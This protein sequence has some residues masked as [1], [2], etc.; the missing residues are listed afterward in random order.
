MG[1]TAEEKVDIFKDEL[2]RIYDESIREFTRLCLISAPDYIFLDCPSSSTGK[3]HAIDEL[4]PQGT[5]IHMKKI[6]T[7]AYELVKALDCEPNRDLVLAACLIHDLRKQGKTRTGFTQ[8]NHPDLAAQLVDEVQD[9]TQLLTEEQYQII[10]NGV[11]FHYGP[12]G[13]GQWFKS[14][15][16]Y[17]P[18]ELAVFLSDYVVSKRFIDVDYRR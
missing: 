3:Y 8:K 1:I 13:S 18:E 12:W 11:G 14:M 4:C 6:F 7:M 16:E 5:I 9:A 17:T 10:R 15:G 2:D